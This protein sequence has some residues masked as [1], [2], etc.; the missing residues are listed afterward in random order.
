M[1]S[2][3]KNKLFAGSLPPCSRESVRHLMVEVTVGP[4]KGMT[5][6]VDTCDPCAR[7]LGRTRGLN[8]LAEVP[9]TPDPVV[10]D[11]ELP[12]PARDRDEDDEPQS[13]PYL[14]A[15]WE[16]VDPDFR[17]SVRKTWTGKVQVH[18]GNRVITADYARAHAM[19]LLAAAARADAEEGRPAQHTH[20][21]NRIEGTV[22]GT[23]IQAGD[24]QG[25][26]HL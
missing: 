8:I 6:A 25:G 9:I 19:E 18:D 4:S 24:I 22:Y 3:Q 16:S 14:I 5:T 1:S 10:E 15:E 21:Q 11:D 23:A 17:V 20:L 26:L 12:P 7:M 13:D 2:C